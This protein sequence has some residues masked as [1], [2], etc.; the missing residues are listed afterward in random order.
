MLF[1]GLTPI[2]LKD[3]SRV[4]DASLCHIDFQLDALLRTLSLAFAKYVFTFET[5]L[6]TLVPWNPLEL[7]SVVGW[8]SLPALSKPTLIP[9]LKSPFMLVQEVQS[10]MKS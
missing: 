7:Y 6:M 9:F 10:A 3:V 2:A 8:T 1:N 4:V 5:W